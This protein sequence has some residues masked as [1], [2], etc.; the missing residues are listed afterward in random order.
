MSSTI[1]GS[2]S[3]IRSGTRC[4]QSEC[5]PAKKVVTALN[6]EF[7]YN[8]QAKWIEASRGQTVFVYEPWS[9]N[10]GDERDEQAALRRNC[11]IQWLAPSSRQGGPEDF[12]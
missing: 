9:D 3:A 7:V 6:L 2:M 8:G 11:P 12:S 10:R 5:R 4:V 1:R